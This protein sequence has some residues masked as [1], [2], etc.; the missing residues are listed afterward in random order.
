MATAMVTEWGMSQK[1][2]YLNYKD[3]EQRLHKPFSEETARNIDTEV[4]RIVDE[5]YQQCKDLLTEKKAEVQ[6]IAEELLKKEMLVRDDLVRILG[7]RPFD[8]PGEF[9]KYF[10]GKSA[11]P[12]PP[13]EGLGPA[14][15]EVPAPTM[16]KKIDGPSV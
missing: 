14:G 16:V 1:I 6:A 15:P 2:G 10:S 13:T 3:D 11:P 9:S 12:P 7:P 8:D 4:R 5:A